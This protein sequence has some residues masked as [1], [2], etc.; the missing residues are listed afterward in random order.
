VR[1]IKTYGQTGV[2]IHVLLNSAVD[3]CELV[4]VV[5]LSWGNCTRHPV[6]RK[7]SGSGRV[8]RHFDSQGGQ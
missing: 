3:G 7:L 5:A 6:R 4:S 8:D 1:A 2:Y